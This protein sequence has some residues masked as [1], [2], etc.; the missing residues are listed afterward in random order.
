MYKLDTWSSACVVVML[1]LGVCMVISEFIL[2]VKGMQTNKKKSTLL[3]FKYYLNRDYM[4]RMEYRN[5]D[6]L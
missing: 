4:L 5:L 2:F 1:S 6:S 3:L